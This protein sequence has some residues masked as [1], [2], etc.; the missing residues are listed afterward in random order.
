LRRA[1]QW[2][3]TPHT[4]SDMWEKAMHFAFT[5]AASQRL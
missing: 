2:G 4:E 1:A 3:R 5:A